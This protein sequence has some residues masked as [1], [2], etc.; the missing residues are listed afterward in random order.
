MKFTWFNLMPWLYLPDDFG[1]IPPIY[2]EAFERAIK[3]AQLTIIP[4]AG[5]IVTLKQP[6]ELVAAL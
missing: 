5:H 1:E 2:G 3:G 4:K 6:D